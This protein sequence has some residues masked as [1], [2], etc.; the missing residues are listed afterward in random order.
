MQGKKEVEVKTKNEK[1]LKQ[2]KKAE[3]KNRKLQ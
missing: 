2:I 3:K 1:L